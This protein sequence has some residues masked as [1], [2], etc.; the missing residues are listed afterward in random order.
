VVAA[1]RGERTIEPH[2]AEEHAEEPAD[3]PTHEG[4]DGEEAP[5]DAPPPEAETRNR[6][7]VPAGTERAETTTTEAEG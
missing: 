7:H 6:P 2:H 1:A 5:A 3:E 4:A